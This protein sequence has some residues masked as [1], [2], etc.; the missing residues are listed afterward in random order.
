VTWLYVPSNSAPATA[1]SPSDCD[2]A[3]SRL[4]PSA[5][6]RG[7]PMPP[8][9]WSRRWKRGGWIRRLSGAI[10]APS[11][12][13]RGVERW[14]SSVLDSHASR[15]PSPASVS[16]KQ[17]TDGSG[18][19]SRASS[20]SAG[21]PSCSSRTWNSLLFDDPELTWSLWATAS[22]RRSASLRQTLAH[23]I[24]E[25]GGGC[26]VVFPTPTKSDGTGGPGHS[27]RDG[28]M[29]LRTTVQFWPTPRATDG[30]KGGPNQRG[31]KGDL[32]L[33]SAV[34]QWPT[35][36]ARDWRKGGHPADLE[37]NSPNL[38]SAVLIPTPTVK[39]NHNRKGSSPTSGDGLATWAGGSLN[40]M[41]V[42][43]LMGVPIGWTSFDCSATEWS[44]WLAQ[45]RSALCSLTP[46][47]VLD[48][49]MTPT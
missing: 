17:T 38:P 31:R 13:D 32:M 14:I 44:R 20:R 6:S 28:G 42:A 3:G 48:R 39:G 24:S 7:K 21:H 5:W 8:R 35:P 40:P 9:Y 25:I 23:R 47:P 29:N 34:R 10:S 36:A 12:L 4:A 30:A 15:G 41:W 19:T 43:W 45:S 37:R 33:P 11:T 2:C 27:G 46:S 22:V 18:P 49:S 16:A 1:D 26:S